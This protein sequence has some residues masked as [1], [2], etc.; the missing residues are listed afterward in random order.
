ME[1]GFPLLPKKQIDFA[2]VPGFVVP[3]PVQL[4]NTFPCQLTADLSEES[5]SG[6]SVWPPEFSSEGSLWG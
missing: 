2:V 5:R 4:K 3:G 1:S 6:S